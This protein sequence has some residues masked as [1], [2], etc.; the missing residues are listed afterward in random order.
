MLNYRRICDYG[1]CI[2]LGWGARL[3]SSTATAHAYFRFSFSII[4]SISWIRAHNGQQ[5]EI[6]NDC[7]GDS[8]MLYLSIMLRLAK[9]V[10]HGIVILLWKRMARNVNNCAFGILAFKRLLPHTHGWQQQFCTQQ[11]HPASGPAQISHKLCDHLV[12][13]FFLILELFFRELVDISL[14][15]YFFL[16]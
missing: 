3:K 7:V 16:R 12:L 6:M 2:S 1:R 4:I 10:I 14:L 5:H 9:H 15:K 11:L 13:K 8:S